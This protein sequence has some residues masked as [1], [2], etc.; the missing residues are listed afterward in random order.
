MGYGCELMH[1]SNVSERVYREKLMPPSSVS[2]SVYTERVNAWITGVKGDHLN[3]AP[4]LR[5]YCSK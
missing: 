2:E 1:P 4:K 3:K 5:A